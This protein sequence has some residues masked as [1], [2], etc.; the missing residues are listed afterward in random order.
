MAWPL[1]RAGR[2]R[3][4]RKGRNSVRCRF[5]WRTG[6]WCADRA[7]C[8]CLD[9]GLSTPTGS[10]CSGSAW[11]IPRRRTRC[12]P[13]SARLRRHPGACSKTRR[14]ARPSRTPTTAPSRRLRRRLPQRVADAVLGLLAALDVASPASTPG[15]PSWRCPARTAT[16]IPPGNCCCPARRWRQSSPRTRRSA[17]SART[18]WNGTARR[19]WGRPACCGPS[20]CS[21]RK[22]SNSTSHAIDLDLD[23]ADEWAADTR[24]PALPAR[25]WLAGAAAGRR[26]VH[27]RAGPRS[28]RPPIA[29]RWL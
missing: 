21:P 5:R 10:P 1:R 14:P 18:W 23:G 3:P 19:P 28:G 11:C 4:R 8:C 27:R 24:A 12:S 7:G 6:G 25:G 20:A 13:G 17:P 26:R 29:G 22:T 2:A 16:G 15:W 9:R